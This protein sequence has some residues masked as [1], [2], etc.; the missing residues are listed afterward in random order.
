VD[1]IVK[2]YRAETVQYKFLI[3]FPR[4]G[5]YYDINN[6]ELRKGWQKVL[7]HWYFEYQ[8]LFFRMGLLRYFVDPALWKPKNASHS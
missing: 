8:C 1:G 3:P 7:I 4:Y 2:P 5:V 6:D